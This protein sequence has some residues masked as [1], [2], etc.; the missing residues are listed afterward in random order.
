MNIWKKSNLNKIIKK[1]NNLPTIQQ[2]YLE[3]KDFEECKNKQSRSKKKL[4]QIFFSKLTFAYY[5]IGHEKKKNF[6][7]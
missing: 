3:K 5:V 7:R 1:K 6:N 2:F 4:Y